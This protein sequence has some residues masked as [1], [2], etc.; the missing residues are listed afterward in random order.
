[1]KIESL[2]QGVKL[3]TLKANCCTKEFET[4]IMSDR[5][6]GNCYF[7]DRNRKRKTKQIYFKGISI[8]NAELAYLLENYIKECSK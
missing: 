3:V 5:D 7:V 4:L 6:L 8:N 1:M 2:E